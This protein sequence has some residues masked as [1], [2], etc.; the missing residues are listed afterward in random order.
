MDALEAYGRDWDETFEHRASYFTQEFWY[1]LVNCMINA[2]KGTPLS[3]SRAC[4]QMKSG[5]N[6][7]REVRI[8]KAGADGYL[9]KSRSE[10]DQREAIVV[11]SEKLERLMIGHFDRT[12][13]ITIDTLS[14]LDPE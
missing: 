3:V 5:S 14:H 1:L 13:K 4:Q 10:S 8:K 6:R 7:T 2:W 12:L 9:I 11:P